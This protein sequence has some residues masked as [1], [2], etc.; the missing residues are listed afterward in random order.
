MTAAAV[1]RSTPSGTS[2]SPDAGSAANAAA[3]PSACGQ[4]TRS[5]AWKPSTPSPT[6]TTVPAPSLPLTNGGVV[7]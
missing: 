5:P 3:L 4:A 1:S 6:A 2:T 7:G